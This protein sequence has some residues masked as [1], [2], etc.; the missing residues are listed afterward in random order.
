MLQQMQPV[1]SITT[2]SFSLLQ[3]LFSGDVGEAKDGDAPLEDAGRN[4]WD[5]VRRRLREEL[6]RE[7]DEQEIDEWLRQHTEGY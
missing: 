3:P 7:P 2:K 6:G 5:Y 4:E 1:S